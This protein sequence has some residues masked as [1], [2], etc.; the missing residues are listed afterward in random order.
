MTADVIMVDSTPAHMKLPSA[1]KLRPSPSVPGSMEAAI[2]MWL[3]VGN[4][5]KLQQVYNA[6]HISSYCRQNE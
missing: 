5:Q 3:Q 1:A 4:V 6:V 2:K